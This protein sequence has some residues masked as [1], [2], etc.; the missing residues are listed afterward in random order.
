[1]KRCF[2]RIPVLLMVGAVVSGCGGGDGG[3][4]GSTP[5]RT[6][7]NLAGTWA[8]SWQG[9][10]PNFGAV[11]GY[12]AAM[13]TQDASGITG[14][15][16]L[17]GDVDCI[18]GAATGT[19]GTTTFTGTL[20]R[21]PCRL[22]HWQLTALS[23]ADETA[24]GSW[25]QDGSNAKGTFVGTRIAV[26]GGP[27][28]DTV[29]PPGGAPGT[30]VTIVGSGFD[31]TAANN[32][33]LFAPSVPVA[34]VLSSNATTLTLR[35]PAGAAS[36]VLRLATPANK[37]AS[38]RPFS[39]D[40][41]SPAQLIAGSTAV[42][43]AP[44][45]LALSPD[46]RKLYVANSGSVTLINTVGNAVLVPNTSLPSTP[47]ANSRGIAVSPDGKRVYVTAASGVI[48]MDAAL[49]Q[50]I[51]AESVSTF[52]VGSAQA[53]APQSLAISPDGARLFV[54]D[55]LSGG[56]VRIV[57]LASR[58]YV[59]SA[60]VGAGLVPISVA[61]SPD[62]A[63][64]Y[65]GIADP[66]RAVSDSIA[67]LD[68][69]TGAATG[70]ALLL[71][72]GAIPTAIAFAPDGR[73]AYVANRGLNT[74][75]VIDTATAALGSPITGFHSP[76]GLAMSPDGAKLFVSNG[77]DDT[78]TAIDIASGSK[79]TLSVIVPGAPASAPAGVAISAD[80]LHAYVAD[81]GANAVTE[82]GNSGAVAIAL[83]GT[84]I[85]SVT[86]APAG[87]QCG[88]GCL[89]RFPMT[90]QV[91][92]SALA[93]TGSE[94][95]GWSGAGCGSGLV[96][97]QGSGVTCTATF[98]NTSSTTGAS[99]GA[100]CFIATAAYGSPMAHE[101]VLLRAFR[102][103]HLLTNAAGRAFVRFYYRYSPAVAAVIGR[104]ESLRTATRTVLW[105]VVFAV[106][107][108]VAA[109]GLLL[110]LGFVAVRMR[111]VRL[112]TQGE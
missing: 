36:G 86:S 69:K 105:P 94:F 34:A 48:A 102:D 44:Q 67:V 91:A 42:A 17:L 83:A 80:G 103:Q 28:I 75:A 11:T 40:V 93:G 24:A 82:I 41:S 6:P 14:S 90:T 4:A 110:L 71:G 27:R 87:I 107:S 13:L 38:P 57:T 100:G 59:S 12:W 9:T 20:D 73:T 50:A 99:G 74:V 106:K 5:T 54:A 8:G 33:L 49:V 35:V 108:P 37:A 96:T 95:S 26:A 19:A 72:V 62:G 64:V 61:A 7:P 70:P 104:H 88:T 45:A 31:P 10:D 23:T 85:G 55:D 78:V 52:S 58:T 92:L 25:T 65:A 32:S 79:N 89:A 112:L 22:N 47:A 101:V 15:G 63:T 51:A 21:A 43:T 2:A 111:R 16:Y 56:V 81:H 68:A 109:G 30:V 76:T 29:Y 84:G 97:V 18:E 46:G 39:T 3:T 1:M 98:R 53:V 77:G 66:S 60:N